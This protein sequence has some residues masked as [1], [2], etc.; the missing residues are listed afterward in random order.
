MYEKNVNRGGAAGRSSANSNA[1]GGKKGS[2]G[3]R[4]KISMGIVIGVLMI[5]CVNVPLG[6]SAA[7]KLDTSIKKDYSV[8]EIKEA[9][10][11]AYGEAQA[12]MSQK[13]ADAL[14]PPY[15][16]SGGVADIKGMTDGA[17]EEESGADNA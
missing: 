8:N 16:S 13:M 15:T 2:L 14:E 5:E 17:A 7:K 12:V 4:M 11:G 3:L 9:L 6:Q 10:S 1:V